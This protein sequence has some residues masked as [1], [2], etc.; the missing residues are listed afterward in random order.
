MTD[1]PQHLATIDERPGLAALG[2]QIANPVRATVRTVTQFVIGAVPALNVAAGV[3]I[4]VL[5]QQ[6]DLVIPGWVFLVLNGILAV[7]ALLIALVT[8]LMANPVVN[9]WI[10]KHAGWLAPLG[11][12]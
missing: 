1:T 2:T 12:A 9:A 3:V 8:R 4:V 10:T 5:Q 11:R 6:T 7:T